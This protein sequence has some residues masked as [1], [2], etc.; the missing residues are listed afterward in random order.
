MTCGNNIG[1]YDCCTVV[2]GDCLEGMR[3]LPDNSVDLVLTDPPYGVGVDY[4]QGKAADHRGQD[5]LPYFNECRRVANAVVWTPGT[6][7]MVKWITSTQPDWV[8]AWYKPNQCSR[9][10]L[11]F[12]AWEPICFYWKGKV[13]EYAH[14]G[15]DAW[16][17]PIKQ[18]P[19]VI[20]HPCPKLLE[21]WV[22]LIAKDVRTV[23]DP[24]MGSGTTGLAAKMLG[25]HYLG[26]EIN[27]EYAEEAEERLAN[28][29]G[30]ASRSTTE[31]VD[32][33]RG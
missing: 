13:G 4:G 15:H 9:S 19:G 16:Y 2:V 33:F 25:R 17:M 18:Q 29:S 11:G 32:L 21:F 3:R 5:F 6:V 30:K 23:L 28:A 14:L 10:S 26:F 1:P 24:F 8:G 20:K 7:N 31:D 12:G 22:K 27:P